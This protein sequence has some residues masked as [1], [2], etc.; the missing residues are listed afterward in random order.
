MGGLKSFSWLKNQDQPKLDAEKKSIQERLKAV[1]VF[2]DTRV[3]WSGSLRTIA[4]AMPEST[5]ITTLAG[6]AEI[7]AGSK[8]GPSR[9]KKKLIVSFETPLAGNGSLP[10]EIDGF[11]AAL[12]ADATLKRHFPLVEV[13]GFRANPARAGARP[14]ASYSVVCLPIAEK[15]KTQQSTK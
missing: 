11:L 2:R 7:E 6:D 3:N 14:S 4:A 5:I 13:S 9:G 1:G 8:S 10:Q 12:R 15:G